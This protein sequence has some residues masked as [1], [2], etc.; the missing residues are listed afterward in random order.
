M[1]TL[2]WIGKSAVINHHREVAYRLLHCDQKLSVGAPDSGNLLVQGDNLLALKALLPY[3][4]GKVKCIYIDPPYNTGQEKWIYNDNVNSPEI[5]KWLGEVV[6]KESEDLSRHD[7]WL[8]MMHPRLS[9]LKDFLSEDGVIF[10]SIDDN[11]VHH[12]RDL[13][14][15]VFGPHN[16]VAT[17]IWQKN[18]ST[19]NDAKY[20][21]ED[22]DFILVYCKQKGKWHPALLPRTEKH[23]SRYKNPDGD[24]RGPWASSD[25]LRM[26]HRDNSVYAIISPSG[27]EWIPRPGT[28]WRHPKEEMDALIA[29]NEVWF[30][31]NGNSKPRR[32]RFLS[33][34]KQGVVPQTIWKY[35]DVGHTQEGK[36]ELLRLSEESDSPFATPKPTRLIAQILRL[37]PNK[38]ILVLDSFAG[39]GTT[40]HSVLQLNKEDGGSRRFILV[41][42]EPDIC[43]DITAERLK[44]VIEGYDNGKGHID[45]LGGGF[46]YCKLG[47]PLFDEAGHIR[48][49]VKFP[50]LAAHVFFTETGSPI[51]TL[52]S[53]R[54]PLL[55]IHE[56]K[57][58]YLLFNGVLGDKRPNGGNVLTNDVLRNLPAHRGQRIIYGEG[59]RLSPERLRREGIIFK[60]VPYEIK[61]S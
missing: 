14:D 10:V 36:Q 53:G 33:D 52:A 5:N 19:K 23:E 32:K 47:E 9:L 45:G 39:S 56:N 7:K 12:L 21:S 8:C 40:G 24:P 54:T 57:A 15:E 27:K 48:D 17:I 61:V 18:F 60:Q 50:E 59:C 49:S 58:V 25:L 29:N 4:A 3:Y 35:N 31:K 26:E 22:H 2:D 30:G 41:E 42:M 20:F 44:R 13:M 38:C 11:E 55:G 1:P 34:V 6:G 43:R 28:S 51:P 37:Y 16:F 46:C